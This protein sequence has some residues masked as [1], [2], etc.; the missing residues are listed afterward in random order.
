MTWNPWTVKSADIPFKKD[1]E[2]VGHG[3]KKVAKELET[4]VLGQNSP[5]DMNAII[6]G[7][8]T[9]CDV[10]MLDKGTFNTGVEGRDALRPIKNTFGQL[11]IKLKEIDLENMLNYEERKI[12]GTK[13]ISP[14][15]L[16][17]QTLN[18]LFRICSVLH[19]KQADLRSKLPA[20][21][22]FIDKAT[23]H[24]LEMTTD[25][26]Y[27][28][29]EQLGIPFPAE[30]SGH[31]DACRKLKILDHPYISNPNKLNEDLEGLTYIFQHITLIFVDKEKG[32]YI[33]N[34][35][36][37]LKF[38]RITRGNPRFKVVTQGAS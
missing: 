7:V 2:G 14:D 38:T 33:C 12:L 16:S 1:Q 29:C 18:R 24:E 35:K 10:K 32:Y 20:V 4:T 37:N 23:G 8:E 9:R 21:R 28:I 27:N 31:I 13:K 36:G 26:Y 6:N 30:M 25:V 3:E 11:L 5:Y 22:P 34:D 15:E 17:V 19:T